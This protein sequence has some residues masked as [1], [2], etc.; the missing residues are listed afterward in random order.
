[1]AALLECA[2]DNKWHVSQLRPVSE[3]D[4]DAGN[5]VLSNQVAALC[6]ATRLRTKG[7]ALPYPTSFVP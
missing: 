6:Q 7:S 3:I 2:V 4:I 1:M 5:T